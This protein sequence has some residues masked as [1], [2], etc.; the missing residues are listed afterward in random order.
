[1]NICKEINLEIIMELLLNS[2]LKR[3]LEGKQIWN[4]IRLDIYSRMSM[5]LKGMYLADV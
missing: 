3:I 2:L 4:I 5:K 1:M